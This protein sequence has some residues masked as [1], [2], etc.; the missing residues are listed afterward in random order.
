MA[1]MSSVTTEVE[2]HAQRV[3]AGEPG[4]GFGLSSFHHSALG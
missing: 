2:E 3:G 1:L 4:T